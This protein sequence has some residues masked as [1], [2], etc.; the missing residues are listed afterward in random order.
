L[1]E[2]TELRA[3]S[4]KNGDASLDGPNGDIHEGLIVPAP[5]RQNLSCVHNSPFRPRTSRKFVRTG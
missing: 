2:Y 3:D 5:K 1:D 4:I